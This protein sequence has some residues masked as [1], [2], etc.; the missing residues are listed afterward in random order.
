MATCFYKLGLYE[1]ALDCIRKILKF[2]LCTRPVVY[3]YGKGICRVCDKYAEPHLSLFKKVKITSIPSVLNEMAR[4]SLESGNSDSAIGWLNSIRKKRKSLHTNALDDGV[5]ELY[6]SDLDIFRMQPDS[7]LEHFQKSLVIFLGN[8]YEID[9]HKNPG[10][11]TGSFAYYRLFEVLVK[12]ASA[13][14]MAY[15]KSSI[16]MILKRLTIL[17]NLPFHS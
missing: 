14:E 6:S 2:K 7:A 17:I 8:Y 5:N 13:W 1:Q 12:K 10:N 15:K 3:E 11:F 4:T 9:I 16:L